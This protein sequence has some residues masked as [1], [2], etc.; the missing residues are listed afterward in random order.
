VFSWV[1]MGLS[2]TREPKVKPVRLFKSDTSSISLDTCTEQSE[3]GILLESS[4]W[5]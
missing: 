2:T 4:F 1:P 3:L 5:V